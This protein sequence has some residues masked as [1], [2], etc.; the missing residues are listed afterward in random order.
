MAVQDI[1]TP[2]DLSKAVEYYRNIQEAIGRLKDSKDIAKERILE[3]FRK[4]EIRQFDTESGFRATTFTR[5]PSKSINVKEA[6]ELLDQDTF[7][8]LLHIGKTSVV[9]S[10]MEIKQE[11]GGE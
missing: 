4:H 8:K 9:L 6:E 10:V 2:D 5:P 7:D 3:H 11:E 1:S